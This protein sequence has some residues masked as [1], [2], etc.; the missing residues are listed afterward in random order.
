MRTPGLVVAAASMPAQARLSARTGAAPVRNDA[1][2]QGIDVPHETHQISGVSR[3]S[4][5]IGHQAA[6]PIRSQVEQATALAGDVVRLQP[7]VAG[8]LRYCPVLDDVL[9]LPG[10]TI[11]R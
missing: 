8:S 10:C 3:N 4:R 1:R 9:G 11:T 2:P 7:S 5:F 6:F